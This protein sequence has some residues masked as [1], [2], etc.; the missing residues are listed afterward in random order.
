MAVARQLGW[1]LKG[2]TNIINDV[3][4]GIMEPDKYVEIVNA[5]NY[6]GWKLSSIDTKKME[7][8]TWIAKAWESLMNYKAELGSKN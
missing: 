2:K 4:G 6:L 5:T 1:T 7:F 3:V 8:N